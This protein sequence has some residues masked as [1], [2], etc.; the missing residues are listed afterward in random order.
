MIDYGMPRPPAFLVAL[1]LA[2]SAAVAPSFAAP[3]HKIIGNVYYVGE[4][5]LACFLIA[6]PQGNILI[7]TGY[8]FS[9]P[10]IRNGAKTLG[11]K[12]EDIKILLVTHA[13][14]DHAAG[15]AKVRQLTHAKMWAIEQEA[16][17]L[18]S[19]GKTDFLFGSMGWFAPVKVDHVFHDGDKITRARRDP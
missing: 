6:T 10:V 5:D 11:L 7:N 8:E 12:F 9:V 18:E 2:V 1:F 15:L 16:P 19:G 14:S 3:P 17:L 13:H 4:D